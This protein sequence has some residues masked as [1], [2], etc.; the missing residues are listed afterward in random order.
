MIFNKVNIVAAAVAVILAG[1][2]T[3]KP[4]T[5]EFVQKKEDQQQ[6]S[7]VENPSAANP[8]ALSG[9]YLGRL[10]ARVQPNISFAESQLQTVK[11]NPEALVE[12]VCSPTGEI[13]SKKLIRSSGNAAWD[14]AVMNAVGKAGTL[15]LDENGNMPPKFVFAFKPR[16]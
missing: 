3:P 1:C 2:S 8:S 4:G 14:E 9:T 11:G 13:L 15:P 12:V 7:A 5:P 16:Y 10:R 6:K